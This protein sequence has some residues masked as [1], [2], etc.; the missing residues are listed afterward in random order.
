MNSLNVWP[1]LQLDEL[2]ADGNASRVISCQGS[3]ASATA[4]GSGY[5]PEEESTPPLPHPP[6]SPLFLHAQV[7]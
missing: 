7:L 6:A 4:S 2:N 5:V 3:R 1:M